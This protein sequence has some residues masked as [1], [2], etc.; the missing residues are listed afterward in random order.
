M[1]EKWVMMEFY[2][3]FMATTISIVSIEGSGKYICRKTRFGFLCDN[4]S[5]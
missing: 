2:G 1:N 3:L 5:V 4:Y